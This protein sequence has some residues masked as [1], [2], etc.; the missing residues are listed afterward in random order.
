MEWSISEMGLGIP[1]VMICYLVLFTLAAI[2]VK[3]K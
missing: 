3:I 2:S 1:I